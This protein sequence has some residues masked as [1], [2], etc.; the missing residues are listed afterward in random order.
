LDGTNAASNGASGVEHMND[1]RQQQNQGGKDDDECERQKEAP[2][3]GSQQQ[4]G[5]TPGQTPGHGDQQG[6]ANR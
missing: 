6:N 3:Q 2:G 4:G 5:G 1:P